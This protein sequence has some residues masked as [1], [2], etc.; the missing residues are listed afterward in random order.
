MEESI[1]KKAEL[2]Y[3]QVTNSK[4]YKYQIEIYE[5]IQEDYNKTEKDK[6]EVIQKKLDRKE[7]IF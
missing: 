2:K 7:R 3:E 1:N 4:F 6:Q 5:I